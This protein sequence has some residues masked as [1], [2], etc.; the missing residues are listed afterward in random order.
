MVGVG[1]YQ[2]LQRS[3]YKNVQGWSSC[4]CA[5]LLLSVSVLCSVCD[6]HFSGCL[7]EFVG[8]VRQHSLVKDYDFAGFTKSLMR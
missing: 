5:A 1:R 7:V 8:R 3:L 4:G 6:R 2:W